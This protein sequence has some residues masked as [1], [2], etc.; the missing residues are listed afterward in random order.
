MHVVRDK[1]VDLSS[2]LAFADELEAK[3]HVSFLLL[4]YGFSSDSSSSET[5][6]ILFMMTW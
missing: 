1:A 6:Q 3:W 5:H 2:A 4:H